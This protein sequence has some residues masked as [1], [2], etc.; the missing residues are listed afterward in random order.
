MAPTLD[1]KSDTPNRLL[2]DRMGIF[3]G[4][5]G[6]GDVVA[7]RT[8]DEQ[9]A[10][11]VKRIIG[12]AGD[13]VVTRSGEPVVVPESHLWVEGDNA[14]TSIDSNRY[15]FVPVANVESRVVAKI[16]P[17]HDAGLVS[18]T[19]VGPEKVTAS[20]RWALV[21]AIHAAELATHAAA[22]H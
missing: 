17:L 19:H 10:F 4:L 16:W 6:R 5:Y 13:T 9:N 2:L 7:M 8:P 18:R 15:G 22:I 21:P 1:G 11:V 12:V 14:Q 3:F 20:S